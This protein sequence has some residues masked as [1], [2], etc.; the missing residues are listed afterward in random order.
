VRKTGWV[1]VN[2]ING[3][4]QLA[5]IFIITHLNRLQADGFD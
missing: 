5:G 4:M 2:S 1:G 3:D